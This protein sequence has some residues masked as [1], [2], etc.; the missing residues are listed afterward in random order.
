MKSKLEQRL[1]KLA[2]LPRYLRE[3]VKAKDSKAVARL[4]RAQRERVGR[5]LYGQR[6][7]P[8]ASATRQKRYSDKKRSVQKAQEKYYSKK[9]TRKREIGAPKKQPE[10]MSAGVANQKKRE[11]RRRLNPKPA[12]AAQSSP[13]PKV[14]T[15]K[16]PPK[17][18]KWPL[19]LKI[20]L[21]ALGLGLGAAALYGS[22]QK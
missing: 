21:P 19:A 15:N 10:P 17:K 20:A 13:Q 11:A 4:P 14:P 8:K 9:E 1:E 3:I 16:L 7:G 22:T 5:Y 6:L 12:P 18:G 2:G